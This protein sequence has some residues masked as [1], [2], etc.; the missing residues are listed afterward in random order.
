MLRDFIPGKSNINAAVSMVFE[1]Q[2]HGL[3]CIHMILALQ[4]KIKRSIYFI[5]ATGEKSNTSVI[6]LYAWYSCKINYK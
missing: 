2:I 1:T 6:I 4:N 3:L 5:P